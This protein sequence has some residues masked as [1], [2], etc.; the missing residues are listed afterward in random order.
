M[1]SKIPVSIPFK[2]ES[3]SE[4]R[5]FFFTK[6]KGEWVSIPFKRESVS[7]HKLIFKI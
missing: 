4:Q 2:R 7:E 1:S 3:V 5:L 6:I